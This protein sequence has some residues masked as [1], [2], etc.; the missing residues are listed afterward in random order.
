MTTAT[1][2]TSMNL[3]RMTL[4][5]LRRE[6][7]GAGDNARNGRISTLVK[8]DEDAHRELNAEIA[9]RGPHN[10]DAEMMKA[11]EERAFAYERELKTKG[12][13]HGLQKPDAEIIPLPTLR[14]MTTDVVPA[15]MPEKLMTLREY[16][17][18]PHALSES[19]D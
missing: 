3:S 13:T 2:W 4:D 15:E 9:R 19:L 17:S 14:V 11:R 6:R 8:H 10:P 12:L 18:L 16:R 1:G 5:Q 7:D